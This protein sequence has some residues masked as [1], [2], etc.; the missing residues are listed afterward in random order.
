DP[1]F[2]LCICMCSKDSKGA[3]AIQFSSSIFIVS[4]QGNVGSSPELRMCRV[5]GMFWQKDASVWKP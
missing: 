3:G 4:P 1:F 5:Q 2:A